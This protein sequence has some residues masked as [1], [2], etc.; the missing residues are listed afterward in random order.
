M[1][2]EGRRIKE[3]QKTHNTFFSLFFYQINMTARLWKTFDLFIKKLADDAN[4]KA[5]SATEDVEEQKEIFLQH[6]EQENAKLKDLDGDI[7]NESRF[8]ALVKA[9]AATY[10]GKPSTK[11][12][13]L[14]LDIDVDD[15]PKKVKEKYKMSK[16]KAVIEPQEN[17]PLERAAPLGE[18]EV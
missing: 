10:F 5:L 15:L 2:K 12:S 9:K 8:K 17:A 4:A 3:N 11:D 18:A 1:K 6:V 7:L 13:L 16:R 14:I